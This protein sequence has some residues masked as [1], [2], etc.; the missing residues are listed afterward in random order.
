MQINRYSSSR[1]E[2]ECWS[3]EGKNHG[4]GETGFVAI[5]RI[6]TGQQQFYLRAKIHEL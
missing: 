5:A 2:D 4:R 1:D 3:Y 6:L